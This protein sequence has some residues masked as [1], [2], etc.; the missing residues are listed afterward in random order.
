MPMTITEIK[1]LAVFE[2]IILMEEFWDS[3]CHEQE[4]PASPQWHQDILTERVERLNSQQAKLLT[5]QE[6]KDSNR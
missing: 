2:R 4:P 3:L 1:L 5:L 6:L